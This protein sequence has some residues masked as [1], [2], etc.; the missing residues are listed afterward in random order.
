MEHDKGPGARVAVARSWRG[1]ATSREQRL[2]QSAITESS[3]E[4]VLALFGD[5]E[6]L[7]GGLNGASR[8]MEEVLHLEATGK[9]S[10]ATA[11]PPASAVTTFGQTEWSPDGAVRFF[12]S[13]ALGCL[14]P[15]N[16]TDYVLWLMQNIEPGES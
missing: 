10:V 14:L 3:N 13:L 12:R 4:S 9:T 1:R 7:E 6:H 16:Q 5:L 2:A 15:P 8:Y 11:P